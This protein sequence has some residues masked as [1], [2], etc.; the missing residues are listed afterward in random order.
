MPW[1]RV[2][3]GFANSKPVLKIP[4]RYRAAAVGL[5]TLAG[6]WSAKE[7]TDGFVPE[8]ILDDLA[9]TP[10]MAG[11]LV[12][13]GLWTK[14]VKDDVEGWQF[15]GWSDYQPTKVEVLTRRSEEAE[16]K[17]VAREARRRAAEQAKRGVS[18]RDSLGDMSGSPE[19]V[20]RGVRST[21]PDPTRPDPSPPLLETWVGEGTLVD[22]NGI[23]RPHCSKHETNSPTV[24]CPECK[25]RRLW[26]EANED[27][28]KAD[29]LQ[30]KRDEKAAAAD[31][32]KNCRLC[33]SQGW[34]IGPDGT[35]VEPATKC[36]AHVRVK[37]AS[38]E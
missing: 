8:Y 5:W 19:G 9:S 33:D 11:Q 15:V 20:P 28:L 10:A 30:R 18:P 38:G 17:R 22:A 7:L 34:L 26:D 37:E 29:E 31:A 21:R 4:R 24:K 25:A 1:F 23:P 35:P 32:L 13:S 3:D 27:Q 16:K 6:T 12:L 14:T 2:D 36:K